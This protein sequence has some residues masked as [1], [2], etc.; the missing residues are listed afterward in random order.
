MAGHSKWA[1]IRVHKAAV[2][3]KKGIAFS[4]AAKLIMSAVKQGGP[5]P[6]K[7]LKL[8]YAIEGAREVN[9]PRDSIDRAIKAASGEGAADLESVVYEGRGP[10]GVAVMVE[11][12]TNNR[13]R[14]APEMRKLFEDHSGAL[15][16]TGSCGYLFQAKARCLIPGAGLSED[17]VMEIAMEAGAD[18]YLRDG[19]NWELLAAP[20]QFVPM[21]QALEKAKIKPLESGVA[22][23]PTSKTEIRDLEQAR[24]VLEFLNEL[25]EHDDVEAVWSNVDIPDDVAG[26]L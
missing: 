7:N 5:D 23:V 22:Q 15:G 1:N 21:R 17:R 12:L 2:D 18:D 20:S 24:A 16:A 14:T 19:A 6:E 25:D 8:V 26:Q 9:M 11:A 3:K 13:H 4:K 10:G